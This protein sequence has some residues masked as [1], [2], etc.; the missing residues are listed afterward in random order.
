MHA[1][2]FSLTFHDTSAYRYGKTS[3]SSFAEGSEPDAA[4]RSS[5]PIDSSRSRI[6]RSIEDEFSACEEIFFK[7]TTASKSKTDERSSDITEGSRTISAV[8]DFID[9]I[10]SIQASNS[11]DGPPAR[12]ICK[13]LQSRVI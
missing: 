3:S 10:E 13:H 9:I 2:S 8:P 11:R 7:L 4:K 6:S 12:R 1:Q 5:K